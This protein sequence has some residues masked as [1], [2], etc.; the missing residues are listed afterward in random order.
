MKTKDG[1]NLT[2][3]TNDAPLDDEAPVGDAP[4]DEPLDTDNSGDAGDVGGDKTPD[5]LGL[6]L[7]RERSSRGREVSSLKSEIARMR[8]DI[9][10][11]STRTINQVPSSDGDEPPVKYITTPAELE[12]YNTW[13]ATKSEKK[14]REYAIE[15]VHT[16]KNLKY[17]NPEFHDEIEKELLYSDTKFGSVSNFQ[18]PSQDA[19]V[20]Y[21]LAESTI[22]KRKLA[23]VTAGKPSVKGGNNP[24]TGITATSQNATS[25]KKVIELDPYAKKFMDSIGEKADAKWVQD[26]VQ[27]EDLS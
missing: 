11:L 8:E 2:P 19:E 26:S 21:R 13:K 10:R 7:Q 9:E 16:A 20:N 22:I 5:D 12:A 27:R 14:R 15:Y 3:D 23:E 18:N 4:L 17:M 1:K 24:A 6:Q 25:S